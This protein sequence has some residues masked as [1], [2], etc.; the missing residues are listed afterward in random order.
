MSGDPGLFGREI[1]A[2]EWVL[3]LVEAHRTTVELSN[4]QFNL[5]GHSAGGQFVGRFLVMTGICQ[6]SIYWPQPIPNQILMGPAYMEWGELHTEIE[7][8]ENKS[9]HVDIV[10]KKQTGM[11]KDASLFR[12]Q[13]LLD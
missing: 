9:N 3:K 5:Y 12:L 8:A 2:D 11:G 10:P 1:G 6:E 13:L 7:W 4:E